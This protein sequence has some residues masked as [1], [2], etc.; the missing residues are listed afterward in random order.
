MSSFI[1]VEQE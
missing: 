1:E